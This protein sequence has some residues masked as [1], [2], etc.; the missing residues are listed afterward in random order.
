M[1]PFE[2]LSFNILGDWDER[3]GAAW[4]VRGPRVA[5]TI[6]EADPDLVGLQEATFSQRRS[7]DA[8][9]P[10]LTR[11]PLAV[12]AREVIP[13]TDDPLNT[14]LYRPSRFR[15]ERC[16]VFWLGPDPSRPGCDWEAAFPR[17]ATW[18]RF[19]DLADGEPL[20]FI[21]THFDHD[22]RTARLESAAVISRFVSDARREQGG[23]APVI[24]VGDFN[25]DASLE[26]HKRLLA[27]PPPLLD[28]WEQAN[29]GPAAPYS[30]GTFHDFTGE[31]LT[32][33]GRIDWILFSPPLS[34]ISTA[35]RDKGIGGRYPSDHFPVL[36]RFIRA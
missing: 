33:V 20:L 35:V 18:A 19:H 27:G 6:S 1:K 24:V 12:H 10:G 25:S 34:P 5:R 29:G 4:E 7:L 13:H 23:D 9:L 11:I 15:L 2:T 32:E 22:S 36:S 16:G 30:Q 8:Q 31:A 28:A 21:S 26:V 17:C 3:E 14:I